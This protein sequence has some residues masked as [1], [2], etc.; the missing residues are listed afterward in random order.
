LACGLSS[1]DFA[2]VR[3]D[4][5][6]AERDL[7]LKRAQ[8][9]RLR[10]EQDGDW[11]DA[12]LDAAQIVLT[13]WRD[14]LAPRARELTGK[15]QVAV[16]NRLRGGYTAEALCRCADGYALKPYIVN[17]RRTHDGPKD[18]WK[19][20]AVFIYDNAERVDQGL[21]IAD[22]ADNLRASLSVVPAPREVP[23][24]QRSQLGALG[25]AA[26]RMARALAVFPCR[27]GSKDPATTHGFQDATRDT[28][29]IRRWWEAH[30]ADHVGIPAGMRSG[31]VVLDI[32]VDDGVEHDG[33]WQLHRLENQH[34]EMPETKSVRTPRGGLHMYFQHPGPEIRNTRGFPAPH[35]DIRG[36]GGY[37]VAP[38]SIVNGV[39]YEVDDDTPLAPMPGWLLTLLLDYQRKE[40]MAI[41]GGE[42]AKFVTAG[43]SEG[44]RNDRMTRF[45]G[46]L[47]GMGMDAAEVY[48]I[49][50]KVNRDCRPPLEGR[51]VETIVKS[52]MGRHLRRVA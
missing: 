47:I 18:A 4:L 28:T 22:Q 32:D 11:T 21:A 14:V 38:P 49:A 44:E 12:E 9:S 35:L 42:W 41:R 16:L 15:R 43:A 36:D 48:A 52:I 37:V 23:A 27:E 31:I 30:P 51:E 33:W 2:R 3:E 7:R 19:A 6:N 29:R 50:A 8:L 5:A 1:V 10:A 25:E 45:V 24:T 40:A 39:A 20:D 17:R 26:L 13:H 46:H 34:G